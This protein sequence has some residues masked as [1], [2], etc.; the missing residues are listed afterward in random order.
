MQVNNLSL[1]FGER[2]IL[3]DVSFSLS[4]KSR[5]ALVGANGCGKSTL[6]KAVTGALESD[7]I[8]ISITKGARI[9]YLPQSDIV[10]PDES[11]YQ[12]AEHGYDRFLPLLEEERRLEDEIGKGL[13]VERNAFRISELHES[14]D[15]EGYY[16]R[17]RWIGSILM[18]LGFTQK[19]FQRSA[20]EFSGGYQ[21]RLALA[22]V[23]LENPDFMFLDEPTNYLDIEALTWLEGYLKTYKGGLVLVSH[24]QDFLDTSVDT[25]FELF[26]GR[27][28]EYKGNYSSYLVKREEE[29]KELEKRRAKQEE[30]IKDKEEFIERFRYKATKARQVQSRIKMLEKMDMI[31]VPGHLKKVHFTFPDAPPSGNDVVIVENLKK[32]YGDNVIYDGLSFIVNKGERLAV[33][34]RN[35]SGKSTLLRI[36]AKADDDYEGTMRLGANVKPGYF[37]QEAEKTLDESR[38]VLEEVE[39]ITD[40]KDLP[41][42]RNMLGAFLFSDDDVL[43]K[44]SVLS[45]GEKSRLALLKIL[46]HPHNLLILD[47]PTNHLDINTKEMLLEALSKYQGTVI[48]VSHDKHF[49]SHLATRIMYVSDEKPEFFSGDWEYFNEKLKEK[50]EQFQIRKAGK[51]EKTPSVGK[52]GHEEMKEERNKRKKLEKELSETEA[53][54]EE[55]SEKINRLDEEMSKVE[56]YSSSEKIRKCVQEKEELEKLQ[57]E[58]EDEWIKLSELLSEM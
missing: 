47:E 11:V 39:S 30:E 13:N 43:K 28:K 51:T 36:I 29:I 23:L 4:E 37:D 49:I 12:S 46:M 32:R 56:V 38:T 7:G 40:T 48:F 45:G 54:L 35:G 25:V 41:K 58:K 21:M 52:K 14:L 24:D 19:D 5:V 17:D 34:G 8:A 33:T 50:E 15:E 20:K 3:D 55:I 18:G 26:N 1:S 27:L 53:A 10:F 9:S 57:S 42:V 22:K 44:C 6:L 16:E 31:E 2:R